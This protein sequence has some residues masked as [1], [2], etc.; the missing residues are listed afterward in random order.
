[1]SAVVMSVAKT[2]HKKFNKMT[3]KEQQEGKTQNFKPFPNRPVSSP[4]H[5]KFDGTTHS[6]KE[7]ISTR[8]NNLLKVI[9]LYPMKTVEKKIQLMLGFIKLITLS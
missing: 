6:A 8:N 7:H 3:M 2:K 4:M 1:M 5:V 9:H